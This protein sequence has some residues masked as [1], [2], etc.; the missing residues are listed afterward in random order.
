MV[1][2]TVGPATGASTVEEA[3]RAGEREIPVT[4]G[5]SGPLPIDVELGSLVA[6]LSAGTEDEFE[7]DLALRALVDGGSFRV[8]IGGEPG[9]A[10]RPN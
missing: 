10:S 8:A 5:G 6:A 4:Y 1:P 3:E 7:L 2:E 9:T